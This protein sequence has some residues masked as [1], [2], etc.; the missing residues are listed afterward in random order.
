[1]GLLTMFGRIDGY[2][3]R[4]NANASICFHARSPSGTTPAPRSVERLAP[5]PR[6]RPNVTL[7][8]G[9]LRVAE[10]ICDHR[11]PRVRLAERLAA[12]VAQVVKPQRPERL[13]ARVLPEVPQ[14]RLV[15]TCRDADGGC[16]TLL[17]IALYG[18]N[19]TAGER[20]SV[21]QLHSGTELALICVVL[22]VF[23]SSHWQ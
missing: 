4:R 3:Q 18:S 23:F 7:G 8:R 20:N 15:V 5:C 17:S 21:D 12:K 6:R 19:A 13:A 9:R 22:G 1:M 14:L 16:C 2:P 10:N 11:E